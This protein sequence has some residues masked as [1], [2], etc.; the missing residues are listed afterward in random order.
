M[1]KKASSESRN[2]DAVPLPP[3][4]EKA[5]PVQEVSP[6]VSTHRARRSDQA[7]SE[8]G[9]VSR[10]R[11]LPVP[12]G[13]TTRRGRRG[14][15]TIAAP[16]SPSGQVTSAAMENLPEETTTSGTDADISSPTFSASRTSRASQGRKRSSGTKKSKSAEAHGPM[17]AAADFTAHVEEA[18]VTKRSKHHSSSSKPSSA[19]E[20]LPGQM[21]S[22]PPAPESKALTSDRPSSSGRRR[23]HVPS[24]PVQSP[25][26]ECEGLVGALPAVV[27]AE[28]LS[29]PANTTTSDQIV[30]QPTESPPLEVKSVANEQQ[31]AAKPV[32][33][34]VAVAP[35]QSA[36]LPQPDIQ[37]P[38]IEAVSSQEPPIASI[39]ALS[40]EVVPAASDRAPEVQP[41]PSDTGPTNVPVPEPQQVSSPLD[42]FMDPSVPSVTSSLPLVGES[43]SSPVAGT[44]SVRPEV[45]VAPPL[46]YAVQQRQQK[47]SS[48]V[49]YGSVTKV[50]EEVLNEGCDIQAP[51]AL[52]RII[53]LVFCALR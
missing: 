12:E 20:L 37:K 22:E 28:Q 38:P 21:S 39:K 10:R 15:G 2:S 31:N 47:A 29:T 17:S 7:S 1:S 11:S 30:V 51:G 13:S 18:F 42:G 32:P 53:R 6:P 40:E 43:P 50:K 49:D 33:E 24:A 19:P 25:V 36:E 27:P 48:D 41:Q 46:Y 3:A 52:C 5:A 34:P 16:P 44:A 45:I 8:S 9:R 26:M 35:V 4:D 14:S 23:L